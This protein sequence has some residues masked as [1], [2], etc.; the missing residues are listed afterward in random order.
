MIVAVLHQSSALRQVIVGA[1]TSMGAGKGAT[2]MIS[3]LVIFFPMADLAIGHLAA[4]GAAEMA[5]TAGSGIVLYSDQPGIM[6][7]SVPRAT[8]LKHVCFFPSAKC[9]FKASGMCIMVITY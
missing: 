9:V 5:E 4:T 7:S 1:T 3:G 2:T 8:S 6:L